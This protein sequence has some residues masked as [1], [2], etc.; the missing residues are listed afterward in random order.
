[1]DSI[2]FQ[3]NVLEEVVARPRGVYDTASFLDGIALK[4]AVGQLQ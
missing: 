3:V 4:R 2:V 1:M